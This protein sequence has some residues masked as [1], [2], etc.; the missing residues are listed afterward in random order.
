MQE[1]DDRKRR[2]FRVRV[3][4]LLSILFVVVLWAVSNIRARRARNEWKRTL[5]VAII[6]VRLGP[7]DEGAL[8]ALHARAWA[9][10]DTLAREL[11]RYRDTPSKPFAIV[12]HGPVDALEAAPND[13]GDGLAD[14][15]SFT[16][17]KWRWVRQIDA[18]GKID[19]GAYD[20][21]VYLIVRAPQNDRQR[22]IE[23]ASEQGGAVG[24]IEVELALDMV[25]FALFVS[26][27][28]L[29]HTLGAVDKYD[30]TGRVLSPTGLAD[31][32]RKVQTKVELMTRGRPL[33]TG[34]EKEP[35]SL[36]ELRVNAF[37]AGEIGWSR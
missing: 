26:A 32:D 13:P 1:R 3:G 28:E 37:T 36:E 34:G 33:P 11:H 9:L 30:E 4:I 17:K 10:E 31:P 21:R 23:G 25:D 18:W 15:A 27:H 29:F 16:W 20:S 19:G 5:N 24:T 22:F 8:R 35:E 2:F 12:V 7:V 14:L 6:V